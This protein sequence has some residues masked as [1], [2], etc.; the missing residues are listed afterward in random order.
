[1]TYTDVTPAQL[2]CGWYLVGFLLGVTGLLIAKCLS[3]SRHLKQVE[4]V[5]DSQWSAAD[6]GRMIKNQRD[7][8]AALEAQVARY[9]VRPRDGKGRFQKK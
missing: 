3:L 5:R 6:Y 9:T 2:F 4:W 7:K 8:I 1:M